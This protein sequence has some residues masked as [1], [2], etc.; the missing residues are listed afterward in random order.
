MEPGG[1]RSL[2]QR[3]LDAATAAHQ[4]D[5][6]VGLGLVVGLH[7]SDSRPVDR[8]DASQ[9]PEWQVAD[10]VAE[11]IAVQ[12]LRAPCLAHLGC[13]GILQPQGLLVTRPAHLGELRPG[14]QSRRH[15]AEEIAPVE[16]GCR[17]RRR[18]Q[19]DHLADGLGEKCEQPVVGAGKDV[20]RCPEGD[21]LS[22]GADTW[23]DDRDVYGSDR[24]A[25]PGGVEQKGAL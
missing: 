2:A 14:R 9:R 4:R 22:A 8:L 15:R 7:G 25:S 6:L 10:H 16:C 12:H 21:R 3:E 24:K 13:P 1:R 20:I 11:V 19:L 5:Q 18:G 23:I 17:L